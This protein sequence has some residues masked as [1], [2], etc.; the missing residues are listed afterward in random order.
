MDKSRLKNSRTIIFDYDGTLH[1]STLNYI[2][3]FKKA[4]NYLMENQ[5]AV[6]KD[7]QDEE[8]TKWLGYNSE[9]MW[10]NFMPDLSKE[11]QIAASKI[12]GKILLEKVLSKEA[13]LYPE[14]LK[15]LT[16]LKGKGYKLIF[17]SN[18]SQTYMKAHQQ[19]FQLTRYFDEMYCTE[20]VGFIPK[21]RIFP[22]V[23]SQYQEECLIVGDRIHDLEIGH[24][25]NLVTIGCNYGFGTEEE[26]QKS[27]IRINCIRELQE[28]L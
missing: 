21:H 6:P 1:D 19:T 13:I 5:K 17:L 14:A 28:I 2:T 3:A 27:D 11:Y 23:K 24:Y 12:I 22:L 25:H 9:E 18:C 10:K 26:M 15:T 20:Q 7:W 8:I 4:Y 16:Y